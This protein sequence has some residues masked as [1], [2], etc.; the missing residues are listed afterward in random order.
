MDAARFGP[1]FAI[2]PSAGTAADSRSPDIAFRD[3]VPPLLLRCRPELA[4]AA[5]SA[6]EAGIT[7]ISTLNE[8]WNT[9][10]VVWSQQFRVAGGGVRK[11]LPGRQWDSLDCP[12]L[13]LLRA[14]TPD[15]DPPL[16][17]AF[18]GN[19]PPNHTLR[20]A[21]QTICFTPAAIPLKHTQP[22]AMVAPKACRARLSASSVEMR[23]FNS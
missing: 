17:S 15:L 16:L 8:M 6:H 14:L 19:T 10:T 7:I 13:T 3:F 5:I 1:A 21:A 2:L 4:F 12:P 9:V 23:C 18:H 11:D 22:P 20:E